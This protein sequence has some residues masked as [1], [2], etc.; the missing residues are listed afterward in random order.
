MQQGF[1]SILIPCFNEEENIPELIDR[2]LP[3]M[4]RQDL[5]WEIV[6]VDDGSTDRTWEKI[7]WF[8][9][10]V[11]QLIGVRHSSN[12]GI[13]A[14]WET[15][16]DNS[17]GNWVLT[18]DGDLQNAPE[19]IPL[20]INEMR[21][22]GI[23]LVQGIRQERFEKSWYRNLLSTGFSRVL[24]FIFRVK[25]KDV[26][27]G[28]VLYRREVLK[29]VLDAGKSFHLFQHWM[30]LA[31]HAADFRI[32][33]IPTTFYPRHAGESFIKSPVRFS[34]EV[35]KELP[36]AVTHFRGKHRDIA[37]SSHIFKR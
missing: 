34:L 32:S 27:S 17:R 28:F 29:R 4:S 1:I 2:I 18:M 35:L 15:A 7:S 8:M 26:K 14:A 25:L 13:V 16:L 33:Q 30:V 19:E 36:R 12:R 31:A 37:T 5:S 3:V 10:K 22:G 20:L 24:A 11:P 6:L 9:K 21:K 23:D